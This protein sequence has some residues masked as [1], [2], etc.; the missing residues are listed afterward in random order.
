MISELEC[1]VGAITVIP[2]RAM[3]THNHHA[4]NKGDCQQRK[5]EILKYKKRHENAQYSNHCPTGEREPIFL[6]FKNVQSCKEFLEDSRWVR[7]K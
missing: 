5:T 6:I 3:R 2:D 1:T 4:V 7:F